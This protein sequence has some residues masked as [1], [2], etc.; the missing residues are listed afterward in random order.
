MHIVILTFTFWLFFPYLWFSYP[1]FWLFYPR[2]WY[3]SWNK[4]VQKCLFNQVHL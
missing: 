3:K 1:W 2:F 4:Y